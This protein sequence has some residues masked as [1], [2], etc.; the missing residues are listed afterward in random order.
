MNGTQFDMYR[1]IY[2]LKSKMSTTYRE[3]DIE[4]DYNT[5]SYTDRE[6]EL[7]IEIHKKR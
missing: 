2:V 6:R 1:F 7:Y 3:R 5:H 4:R